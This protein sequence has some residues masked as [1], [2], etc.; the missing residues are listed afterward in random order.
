MQSIA[1]TSTATS[2]LPEE[3]VTASLTAEI[4]HDL[5]TG[6]PTLVASTHGNQ[7]DLQVVTPAH[8]LAKV[9]EQH[10]QLDRIATL[11]RRWDA[12]QRKSPGDEMTDRVLTAS[13][14]RVIAALPSAV[15]EAMQ[16]ALPGRY[17]P[18]LAAQFVEAMT[19][20]LRQ[21]QKP[22]DYPLTAA[23]RGP[24]WMA[25]YGCNPECGLDHAGADGEPGWHSTAPLETELRDIDDNCSAA[26]NATVPFLGAQVVVDNYRSQ[27]Y[28]RRTLVWLHYGTSTGTLTP[29]KAREVLTAMRGF[30]AEFEAVVDQAEVIA[31]DDFDGD[32]EVARLDREAEDRRIAAVSKAHAEARA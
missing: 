17:T 26:E 29:T 5:D 20:E 9:A 1:Q 2:S 31:V 32:P 14:E 6:Q 11:A 27:A 19:A 3:S 16:S 28:G 18:E 7:G 23:Q 30:V 4:M 25:R 12:Q 8:L 24:V 13:L 15:T 21:A 10:K 22:E